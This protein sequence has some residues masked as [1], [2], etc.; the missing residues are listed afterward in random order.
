[1]NVRNRKEMKMRKTIE[2]M[3]E[4]N[5]INIEEKLVS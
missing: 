4:N 2:R 1:M 5:K 3:S